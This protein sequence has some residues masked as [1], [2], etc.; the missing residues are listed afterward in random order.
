MTKLCTLII[1][2]KALLATYPYCVLHLQTCREHCISCPADCFN[3]HLLLCD[4]FL[5]KKKK[6][7]MQYFLP[8]F[9]FFDVLWKTVY[10]L[11][12]LCSLFPA[13]RQL[14]PIGRGGFGSPQ[15]SRGTGKCFFHTLTTQGKSVKSQSSDSSFVL[16]CLSSFSCLKELMVLP[17]NCQSTICQHKKRGVTLEWPYVDILC[18]L[19]T[20]CSCL[21]SHQ[22]CFDVFSTINEQISWIF[23]KAF[24]SYICSSWERK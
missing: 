18:E 8:F 5:K 4:S 2:P 10:L 23:T 19:R 1:F 13:E 14:P 22:K 11:Y 6:K 24:S 9:F 3:S 17:I 16:H 20:V 21:S 15:L 12:F 7:S